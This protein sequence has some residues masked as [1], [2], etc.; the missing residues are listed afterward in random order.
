MKS[1]PKKIS[2][3]KKAKDGLYAGINTLCDA[4]KTTLGPK[5]RNVVI[6]KD[7]GEYV[8][9]KDGVTVAEEVELTDSVQNAGAQMVKEVAKQVN[10]EAGDGTTTATVLAHSIIENGLNTISRSSANPVEIK[11]GMEKA[12]GVIRE[13]LSS[14]SK[15]IE[16]ETE[17]QQVA[18]ISAN[19]DTEIG[20]LISE[21]MDK[22]G[23]EGVIT[24]EEGKSS[25]TNLEVV[26]GLQF[27][28]GYLSPY[29]VNSNEKMM[30]QLE[31]AW[32]LLYDKRISSLKSIVKP[33]EMAIQADKPLVIIAEDVDGEALA[34]LIVNKARGTCKVAAVKAPGFGDKRNDMLQD[35]AVLTGGTVISTTKGMKLDKVTPDMFGTAKLISITGKNTTIVDGGGNSDDVLARANDIKDLID[36]SDSSYEIESL[37]ERL[38]KMTGGVAILNIGA[39][40]EIELK[41][42]KYRV[43]DALAATRAAIDEG[44]VPG[45]GIALRIASTE[46]E[47]EGPFVSNPDQLIGYEIVLDACKAPFNAIMENAGLNSDVIWNKVNTSDGLKVPGF[48]ARNE[49]VVDMYE[50]GIVDPNKVT[51]VALEKAVSVS[52]TILTTE[53]VINKLPEEEGKE[54]PM[55][56]GG[57]GIG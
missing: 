50:E 2:F 31:N 35:I 1:G 34:G 15:Q 27:D 18:R 36:S 4:V 28:R 32:I 8:S 38:G 25:E 42:K 23:R 43:E 49:K 19:N 11:R 7:F 17:I 45:G 22:V 14:M 29:F 54:P 51:R 52:G 16:S 48:D 56:G 41:E 39:Q 6:E 53:C 37:Q 33:L 55:M 3:D 12:V 26:E 57:F 30:C 21:A 40:S 47:E 10:D 44:I 20:N 24:V 5:G 13:K 46:A 9:T